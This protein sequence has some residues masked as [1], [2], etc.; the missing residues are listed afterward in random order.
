MSYFL[1]Y[2]PSFFYFI[3]QSFQI[4][5]EVVTSVFN[6]TFNNW[7]L[8][9]L[10]LTGAG[11]ASLYSTIPDTNGSTEVVFHSCTFISHW[12]II[13]ITNSNEF[14]HV[15][16]NQFQ[17]LKF[18]LILLRDVL[19]GPHL[20]ERDGSDKLIKGSSDNIQLYRL[21]YY[22]YVFLYQR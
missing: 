20:I 3:V 1:T 12:I 21:W 15:I 8:V 9:C 13:Q 10:Y 17:V 2:S 4:W 18:I 19:G 6:Y 14:S 5:G 11:Q 7:Q 22:W 16:N